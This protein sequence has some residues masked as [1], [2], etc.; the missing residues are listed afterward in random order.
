MSAPQTNIEKQKRR[1]WAPL[2]GSALV[3]VFGVAMILWWMTEEAVE[4]PETDA[5]AA[6]TGDIGPATGGGAA[7]STGTIGADGNVSGAQPGVVIDQTTGTGT[8][9]TLGTPP[10]AI[11]D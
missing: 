1:H 4:A 7:D 11:A 5:P 2:V 6:A 10:A 3:V 9:D 8:A